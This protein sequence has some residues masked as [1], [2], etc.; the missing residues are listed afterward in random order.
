MRE[1]DRDE[2]MRMPGVYRSWELHRVLVPGRRFRIEP[3]GRDEDGAPLIA[4]FSAAL[5]V[6]GEPGA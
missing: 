5:P 3:A 1:P 2:F 6:S 4:V